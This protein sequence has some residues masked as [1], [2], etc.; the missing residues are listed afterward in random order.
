M[1]D[2]NVAIEYKK[3]LAQLKEGVIS[4]SSML[5]KNNKCELFIGIGPDKKPY[6][7]NISKKTLSD[8]SNEIRTNLKPLPTTLEIE[9]YDIDGIDVIR[10]YAE[11]SDT[12]Y[13]AYCRYYYRVDDAD[14]PMSNMQLQK[15]FEDND[16]TYSKWEEKPTNCSYD[17]IDE[18]LL[19]DV[20]RKANEY[21]R[22]NY[23]YR[24]VRE[25]LVKLD[26]IDDDGKIKTAGYYL[27]SK[28]K[29]I[30]IKEAIYPTDT[31][32][33][34][35]ELKEFKGNIFE[36]IR[37][38]ISYIQNHISYKSE[39]VGVERIETP[40]IPVKAIREIVINAFAHANYSMK[41]DFIQIIIFKSSI[42][43]YNPGTIYKNLDPMMFASS[44]VGSKI[45]NV[46]IASVLYKCGYIDAFGTGF[47]R[48]FTLCIQNNVDY[49]YN[50]D[51]FGFTFIFDRNPNYL[52]VKINNKM[53]PLDKA[54]LSGIRDNKYITIPKLAE[55]TNMSESTI[56]RHIQDMI[57]KG[58]LIRVESRKNGYWA[59]LE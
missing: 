13:S 44:E 20:I 37:E 16:D 18:D 56:Y 15:Y 50:N 25:A 4:L 12:P 36:C 49:K 21:G 17:D 57:N 46:L 48:T 59:I 33:E 53:N 2:E 38:A 6:K 27:F 23:V 31:R 5:N 55:K 42:R 10:I 11:G 51:D 58:L 35:G 26:L 54:I 43:I 32:T 1:K 9:K 47:D 30:T 22:L 45:R 24:N 3:S 29:P 40:E 41:G 8:V 7:Y 14:I 19:I 34:F 39:I 28:N 52:T